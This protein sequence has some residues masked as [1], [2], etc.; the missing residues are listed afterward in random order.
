MVKMKE[1]QGSWITVFSRCL[2]D[3]L[4]MVSFAFTSRIAI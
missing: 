4:L 1:A 3:G 2:E